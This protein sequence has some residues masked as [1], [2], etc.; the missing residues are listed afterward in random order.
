MLRKMHGE[1]LNFLSSPPLLSY[2]NR[3]KVGKQWKIYFQR[4]RTTRGN[5]IMNSWTWYNFSLSPGDER[6]AVYT[7]NAY[8]ISRK[9]LNFAGIL[10][11]WTFWSRESLINIKLTS[12]SEDFAL[13]QHSRWQRKSTKIVTLKLSFMIHNSILCIINEVDLRQ[14]LKFIW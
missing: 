6:D 4:K 12:W 8:N 10:L 3:A 14:K 11:K 1:K 2:A 9:S 7:A 5:D 13:T